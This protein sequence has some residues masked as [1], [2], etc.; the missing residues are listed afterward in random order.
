[1]QTSGATLLAGNRCSLV[2]VALWSGPT[3]L[4]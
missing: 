1:M 3:V 2:A 4:F